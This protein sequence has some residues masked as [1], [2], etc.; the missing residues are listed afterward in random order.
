MIFIVI[1]SVHWVSLDPDNLTDFARD[2]DT[3]ASNFGTWAVAKGNYVHWL[4]TVAGH[5]VNEF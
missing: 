3:V 2:D 1:L 4:T 5:C